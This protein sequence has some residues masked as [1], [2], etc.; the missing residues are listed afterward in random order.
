MKIHGPQVAVTGE[1]AMYVFRSPKER[2]AWLKSELLAC[3]NNKDVLGE[4][5]AEIQ[6]LQGLISAYEKAGVKS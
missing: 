4:R 2:L 3:I 5:L 6:H 1:G